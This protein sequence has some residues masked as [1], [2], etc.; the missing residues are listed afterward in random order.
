M[1][2]EKPWYKEAK[3]ETLHNML[4]EHII[5]NKKN[6]KYNKSILLLSDK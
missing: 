5:Y 1:I 3:R 2:F 6:E 4:W